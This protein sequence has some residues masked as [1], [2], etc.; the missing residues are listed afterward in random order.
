[1]FS[2]SM[3]IV[4]MLCSFE[5][6]G[7]GR[8]SSSGSASAC[9]GGG[10]S[11]AGGVVMVVETSGSRVSGSTSSGNGR[12]GAGASVGD[13]WSSPCEA[14]RLACKFEAIGKALVMDRSP[15]AQT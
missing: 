5:S 6:S 4:A 1:M 8:S 10:S 14:I 13:S 7:S 3:L 2:A 11:S 9:N 12:R 15:L